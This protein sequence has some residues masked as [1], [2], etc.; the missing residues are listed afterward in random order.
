MPFPQVEAVAEES[1]APR[2]HVV[3]GGGHAPSFLAGKCAPTLT[4]NLG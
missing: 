4:G 3:V 2:S 1:A